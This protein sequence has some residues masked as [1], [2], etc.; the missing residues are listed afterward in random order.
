M[1]LTQC[2]Y[3]TIQ[4]VRFRFR[5]LDF[6]DQLGTPRRDPPGRAVLLRS[7]ISHSAN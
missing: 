4:P 7:K 6:L 3:D 1:T 2:F 5:H